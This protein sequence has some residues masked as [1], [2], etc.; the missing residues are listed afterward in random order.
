MIFN[1]FESHLLHKFKFLSLD[2]P[3]MWYEIS[4]REKLKEKILD[5]IPKSLRRGY[6]IEKYAHVEKYAHD[7]VYSLELGIVNPGSPR[8]IKEGTTYVHNK[9]KERQKMLYN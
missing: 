4:V 9:I 5:E 6:D 8:L 1:R 3:C 2:I 7:Y